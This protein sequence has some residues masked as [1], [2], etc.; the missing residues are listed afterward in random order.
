MRT[1]IF[2]ALILGMLI[3]S[4]FN[5]GT[6][7]ETT[8]KDIASIS[9]NE[10]DAIKIEP[11]DAIKEEETSITKDASG[12]SNIQPSDSEKE[13][14]VLK[15]AETAGET[16]EKPTIT[17][18][19]VIEITRKISEIS[20]TTLANTVLIDSKTTDIKS[21]ALEIKPRA[22]VDI[23][24]KEIT[25]KEYIL[26]KNVVPV[27]RKRLRL[28]RNEMSLGRFVEMDL[29]SND[30]EW[31]IVKISYTDS[32]ITENNLSE[33]SLRVIWYDED[34]ASGTFETWVKLR[35]GDPDWVNG[36]G[37]DQVENYVWAN[38]SHSSVYGLTGT[39]V[40]PLPPTETPTPTPEP[41]ITA[42]PTTTPTPTTTTAPTTIPPTTITPTTE[43]PGRLTE[44][45]APDEITSP[46]I[47]PSET[48][49]TSQAEKGV[50]GP[51]SIIVLS[52]I[53]LFFIGVKDKT[54]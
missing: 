18:E 40:G 49:G 50:C 42:T 1:K 7:A 16:L 38:I 29:P 17:K 47:T 21:V 26:E 53:P 8:L 28:L 31:T 13:A 44:T 3:L 6:A 24:A 14:E 41:T 35:K 36:V 4:T 45:V 22:S 37:I 34:P 2:F 15:E 27:G 9:T 11:S 30:I 43:P 5:Y 39:I 54:N 51:T 32:E 48:S 12:I 23:S 25:I 10:T 46:V 20:R 33:D 52:L 19:E